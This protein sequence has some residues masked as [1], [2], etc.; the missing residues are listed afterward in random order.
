MNYKTCA[1]DQ[2]LETPEL[3]KVLLQKPQNEQHLSDTAN[4][5][6]PPRMAFG[7][8]PLRPTAC[9]QISELENMMKQGSFFYAFL[10]LFFT[11]AK[12]LGFERRI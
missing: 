11:D 2:F 5:E 12:Y 7:N 1:R 9:H 8:P 6:G 4:M 3:T 10:F